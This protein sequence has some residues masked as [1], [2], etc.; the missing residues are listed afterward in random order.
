MLT[1]FFRFSFFVGLIYRTFA[2]TIILLHH[3]SCHFFTIVYSLAIL[4]LF[5]LYP[6]VSVFGP[7]PNGLLLFRFHHFSFTKINGPVQRTFLRFNNV[8]IPFSPDIDLLD[9]GYP[10]HRWS[11]FSPLMVSTTHK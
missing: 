2:V 1:L 8:T 3:I 6:S 9:L 7:G 11:F 5:E 4:S 10:T